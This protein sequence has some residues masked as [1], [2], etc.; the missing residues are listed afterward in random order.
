MPEMNPGICQNIAKKYARKSARFPLCPIFS[1]FFAFIS[2]DIVPTTTSRGRTGSMAGLHRLAARTAVWQNGASL[3]KNCSSKISLLNSF[4]CQRNFFSK[5][6][7]KV[8]RIF[9]F[10]CSNI[11]LYV[12]SKGKLHT[13]N[14][15][16]EKPIESTYYVNSVFS[17]E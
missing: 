5:F 4:E 10:L 12:L 3:K 1:Q 11:H 14:I 6:L 7:Q 15:I 13:T 2:S 17:L 9:L 16:N 8:L